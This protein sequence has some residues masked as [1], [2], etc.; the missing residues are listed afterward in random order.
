MKKLLG[1]VALICLLTVTAEAARK[2]VPPPDGTPV[3]LVWPGGTPGKLGDADA[4]KPTLTI[5]PAPKDTANGAAVIVCPGGG[6][7]G[8]AMDYE[9]YEVAQWLNKHGVTGFVLR[10][11]VAPYRHPAPL[12]DAQQAMRIVRSRAAEWGL[13]PARIGM[14]GFSAGG[15]LV[16]TAGTHYVEVDPNATDP[17]MKVGT[18]PDFLILIYPVI[19]FKEPYGHQGSCKNLLGDNPDPALVQS[20]CNDEQVNEKTPP[21][22]L[23][24]SWADTGVPSE[25]SIQFYLALHKAGVPAEMHV[26]EKGPHGFGMGRGDKVLETWTGHCIDWM[27]GRGLMG[28]GGK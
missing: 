17:L 12:S 3:E 2:M 4:D 11:R 27:K 22:F 18:R 8:H 1:I 26:Y 25:N 13:D 7:G 20:L 9:G 6:Y 19:T 28:A 23:V 15:H 24:A 21:S 10:Y 14:L 5:F 16:S